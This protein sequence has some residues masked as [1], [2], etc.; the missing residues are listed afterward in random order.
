MRRFP[1]YIPEQVW[2][3]AS[4]EAKA[5]ASAEFEAKVVLELIACLAK[6]DALQAQVAKLL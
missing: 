3:K 4:L 2:G 6:N 1:F 5:E